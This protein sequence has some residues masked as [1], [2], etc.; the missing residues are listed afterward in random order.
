M[1]LGVQNQATEYQVQPRTGRFVDIELDLLEPNR[2]YDFFIYAQ[3]PKAGR[4]VVLEA[5]KPL[6]PD[7]RDKL[8]QSGT[9]VSIRRDQ[10]ADYRLY[11]ENLL[12]NAISERP[13]DPSAC[14]MAM[15]LTRKCMAR[16]FEQVDLE[17]IHMAERAVRA[18][19]RL[20]LA[21]DRAMYTLLRLAKH[22][23][24]TYTHCCNV[25]LF[26]LALTKQL[27]QKGASFRI[28]QL[29]TAFYFHDIGKS[30]VGLDVLNKP[31]PLDE[32]EW[33]EMKRHPE[34][35][36]AILQNQNVL[37]PEARYVV[38]QH[39]EHYDGSGYP[40]GLKGEEIHLFARICCIAD[41]YDALTSDRPYRTKM[42]P[43]E[44][45]QLMWR[46][47]GPYFQTDLIQIFLEMFKKSPLPS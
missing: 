31:G 29:A 28:H 40:E 41:V 2:E 21:S 44:A 24:Y 15:E 32:P 45:V 17:A 26:A 43:V 19:T 39:H 12:N 34:A 38:S 35:G 4:V 10:E 42:S 27:I 5:G 7:V 25:G 47:M 9:D 8:L 30:E 33:L 6:E 11:L 46:K 18:T 1:G 16:L 22:D 3:S 20:I 14:K 37:T 13:D 36:L 23:P